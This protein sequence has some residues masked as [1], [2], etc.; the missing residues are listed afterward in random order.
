MERLDDTFRTV[1][2]LHQS[3]KRIKSFYAKTLR[4]P[5]KCSRAIFQITL[6]PQR[7]SK[8]VQHMDCSPTPYESNGVSYA[9]FGQAV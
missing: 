6:K 9:S 7:I 2:Q 5:H 3:D 8:S 1:Y 4:C